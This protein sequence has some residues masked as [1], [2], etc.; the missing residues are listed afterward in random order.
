MPRAASPQS[1]YLPGLS[2]VT[3]SLAENQMG[4][5]VIQQCS[6]ENQKGAFATDIVQD[7]AF[8]VLNAPSL[9]SVC[10]LLALNWQIV[11][12]CRQQ[13]LC[14]I[15]HLHHAVWLD[16]ISVLLPTYSTTTMR[17]GTILM[18]FYIINRWLD[19][20]NHQMNYWPHHTSCMFQDEVK[21]SKYIRLKWMKMS[22][23]SSL[24][25]KDGNFWNGI[26]HLE[27]SSRV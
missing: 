24:T 25:S 7:S 9:G 22:P 5:N 4:I 11:N 16:T 14:Y 3:K 13:F 17:K 20:Y 6:I 2:R 1:P 19:T 21:S 10:A 26:C 8:L 18:H 12:S 27:D 15:S 23:I